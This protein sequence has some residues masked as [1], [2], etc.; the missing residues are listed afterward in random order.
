M[1]SS[2]D[3]LPL[4]P[5]RTDELRTRFWGRV[6]SR[7]RSSKGCWLWQGALNTTGYGVVSVEGRMYTAHR[8]AAWLS[9]MVESPSAPASSTSAQHVLHRCDTPACCRPE[10]LFVGTYSDNLR[11]AYEKSR[12]PLALGQGPK[13]TTEEKEARYLAWRATLLHV[14]RFP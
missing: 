7:N 13:L 14:S 3:L 4:Q 1:H 12:R 2:R 9:D 10:H 11:D 6:D 5:H 8:V